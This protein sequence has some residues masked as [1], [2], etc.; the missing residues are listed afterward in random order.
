MKIGLLSDAHGN[1]EGLERCLSA[2]HRIAVEKVY[3]LGDAVGYFSGWREVLK[4]LQDNEVECVMGNHDELVLAEKIDGLASGAYQLRAEYRAEIGEYLN[5]MQTWPRQREVLHGEYTLLFV[6]GSAMDP[7]NG[8]VYPW[9]DHS[10]FIEVDADV[11]AMGHTHRPFIAEAGS[12]TLVNV[13]SCGLPRDVGNLA[14]FASFD[15]DTGDCNIH[16]V[17]ID[18]EKLLARVARPHH[19]VLNCLDRRELEF[20]G[21]VVEGFD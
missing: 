11:I 6:H 9:S 7:T 8:Y 10:A 20:V 4:L 15:S 13:G 21:T 18:T 14:S 5:W 19:E 16:R 3:F 17:R 2:L 1:P 12:R